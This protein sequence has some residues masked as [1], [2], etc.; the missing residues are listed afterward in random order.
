[1]RQ[2]GIKADKL[3]KKKALNDGDTTAVKVAEA[4]LIADKNNLKKDIRE[5]SH[6]DTKYF[7]FV[8]PKS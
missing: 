2:R 7:A 6:D 5:A 1:V 8:R 4:N 3:A